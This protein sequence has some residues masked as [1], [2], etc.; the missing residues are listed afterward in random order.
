MQVYY[1]IADFKPLQNAIVTSGTFDGVHLG[2][3]IILARLTETAQTLGGETVVL[4]FW[5]HPRMV[6]SKDSQN[7]KLL[8][9]LEEKIA[10]LRQ[11][12][13]HHL[14]IIPFT[15][16]FSELSSEEF[17]QQILVET[18]GT[19]KLVIGY[20]HHFGRNRE[21]SFDYLQQ[22]APRYGFEIEEIPRQ[23]IEH[24]TVSSTKI[25]QALLEGDTT[26]ATELLGRNY[27]FTGIVVKGRQLGRTIGYPT[28][29]VQVA[30]N[31]KL[32]PADGIYAVR[33]E[34]RGQTLGGVMSIGFRPTVNGTNRT[35]EVYIFDFNDDV[36]GEKMTVELVEFIRPELKF[37]GL[38]AL[39]KAIDADCVAAV[40]ALKKHS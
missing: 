31:Y 17:I 19:K 24:I 34:V 21:G 2:H 8:S 1:D 10:Y 11:N 30:E 13:V 29:N 14:V 9:T 3:Q 26:I 6:V 28:A 7:L 32:I 33:V 25:R 36:Y 12:G 23:E 39:K 20:D 16:E 4:T 37:D 15:R 27:T 38:E 35:Q 22:H 18:I 5:P 40:A